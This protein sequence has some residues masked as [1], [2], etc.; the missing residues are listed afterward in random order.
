M[1]NLALKF[2][3]F[4]GPELKVWTRRSESGIS[5]GSELIFIFIYLLI[6]AIKKKIRIIRDIIA[7]NRSI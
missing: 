1:S 4:K 7:N 3:S 2:S 5:G 6:N